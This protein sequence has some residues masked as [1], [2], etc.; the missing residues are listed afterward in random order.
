MIGFFLQNYIV[1]LTKENG[2]T[3]KIYS[4]YTYLYNIAYKIHF[5]QLPHSEL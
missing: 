1:S 5:M 3:E 2:T 4:M